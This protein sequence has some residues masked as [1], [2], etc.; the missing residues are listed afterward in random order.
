MHQVAGADDNTG[1]RS[2]LSPQRIVKYCTMQLETKGKGNNS[3]DV[4]CVCDSSTM[5]PGWLREVR[6]RKTGKTAGKL[7]VYIIR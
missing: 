3:K 6:Q 7:D 4:D 1:S 5:P 2:D